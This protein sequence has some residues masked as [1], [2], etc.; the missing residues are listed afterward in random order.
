[1]STEVRDARR[2]GAVPAVRTTAV[3]KHYGDVVAVDDV[4]LSVEP[5]AV[6]ALLGLNGAGKTTLIRML[7][8]MITPTDGAAAVLG[9]HVTGGDRS[10]WARV[11]YLVEAPAAYP[12]LTVRENLKVVARLRRL[13]SGTVDEAIDRLALRPYADRRARA[14]SMG[15]LQRL[16][17]AKALIHTPDLLI[18]DEPVNGLDPAGVVEIRTL[19]A[20]LA[21]E[22]GV[23]VFLS[24]HILAEV[25]RLATRIGI[26]HRGRLLQ[27]VDAA[28]LEGHL[29]RWLTVSTRDD[30]AARAVLAA[31]G[32]T[33]HGEGPIT[34]T[35]T[36]AIEHSDEV[37]ALLA[38]AGCP[39]VRLLVEE[40][41]LEAYFLRVV[42][43]GDA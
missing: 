36:R 10:A 18:L 21:R 34:L 43:A 38:R 41:D 15:N 33:P 26:I 39:P 19:L 3:S 28:G 16:A 37:A 17:L 25:A 7:L 30:A 8:G 42:G 4:T 32:F 6:Y 1:M 2:A 11:G 24:S 13:P 14:L 9:A 31:A 23:T 5:G 29:R 40:E 12:E 20:G 35:G 22:H 27:E